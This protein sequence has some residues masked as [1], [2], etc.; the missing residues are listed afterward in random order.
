M[1]L[2]IPKRKVSFWQTD[3][4]SQSEFY[5][6]DQRNSFFGKTGEK[7]NERRNRQ[8]LLNN[9]NKSYYYLINH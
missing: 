1:K 8:R 7:I 2:K 9:K 4:D 3:L 5:H 6:S